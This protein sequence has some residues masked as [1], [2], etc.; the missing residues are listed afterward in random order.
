MESDKKEKTAF[1]KMPKYVENTP[2]IAA[3]EIRKIELD[4]RGEAT[5]TMVD[6]TIVK[7]DHGYR[8]MH[9]PV[10]GGFYTLDM[11]SN[12]RYCSKESFKYK[13]SKK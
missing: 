11:N 4:D 1:D 7:V 5:L 3:L 8:L 6:K 9:K 2:D 10:V 12:Q 13:Y